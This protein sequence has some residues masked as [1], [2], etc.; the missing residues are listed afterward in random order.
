LEQHATL[1]SW[2][3]ATGRNISTQTGVAF[4]SSGQTDLLFTGA[5]AA[6]EEQKL[7]GPIKGEMGIYVFRVEEREDGAFYTEDDA[8]RWAYTLAGYQTQ[9]IPFVLQESA[10]VEDKRARFY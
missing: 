6:A 1:E 10:K 3:E 9:M 7:C 5:V 8:H 4:G 2:A